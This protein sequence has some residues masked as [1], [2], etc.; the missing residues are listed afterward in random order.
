MKSHK[1]GQPWRENGK[2]VW[3]DPSQPKVQEYDIALAKKAAEARRGRS[4]VRLCALSGRGRPE[5]CQLRFSDA[6][7]RNGIART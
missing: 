2:L 4:A 5:R 3:T 6:S 1:T 7:I